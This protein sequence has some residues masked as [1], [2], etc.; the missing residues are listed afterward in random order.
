MA[1]VLLL[2]LENTHVTFVNLHRR[3]GYFNK[4]R[5]QHVLENSQASP[6][7]PSRKGNVKIKTYE[8]DVRMVAVPARNEGRE[9]L[10]VTYH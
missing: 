8:G 7:R 5:K 9:V 4:G 10:R 2:H 1:C 6:A 3:L